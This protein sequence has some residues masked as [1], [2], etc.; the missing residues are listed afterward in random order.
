MD[1]GGAHTKIKL[2]VLAD[3]LQFYVRAL[4]NQ[5]YHLVYID[6]FAGTG[7]MMITASP[8]SELFSGPPETG[9]YEGSVRR[10]L[11]LPFHSYWLAERNRARFTRLQQNLSDLP[12]EHRD[13][14]R[15]HCGDSDQVLRDWAS[16]IRG[17]ID[18]KDVRAVVFLDPFGMSLSYDTM[19]AIGDTKR[20]DVWFL[21]PTGMGPQ[22]RAK[23]EIK[24]KREFNDR[25]TRMLGTQNG[26]RL[27]IQKA[28]RR[29][30][31]AAPIQ[32]FTEPPTLTRWRI[33]FLTV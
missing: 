5:N 8:E 26:K 23:L 14:I 30:S 33:I 17:K 2:K 25:I 4:K 18:G 7:D 29:C 27:G 19:K 28:A 3:Y 21:V 15:L 13:R 16:E 1:F 9:T 24:S 10:A 6:A 11:A 31:M 22:R 20:A 12:T 32:F